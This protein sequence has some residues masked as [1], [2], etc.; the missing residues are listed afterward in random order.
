MGRATVMTPEVIGKLEEIF[1]LGG[2][3]KEACFFANISPDTLYEYCK[4]NE[5]YTERKEALKETPIL[6]AR[7]TVVNSLKEPENAKWYLERKK[8]AEF[9][10]RK[11]VTG[12]EGNAVQIQIVNYG[13][14]T[15]PVSTETVST[16]FPERMGLGSKEISESS[17]SSEWEGFGSDGEPTKEN[18]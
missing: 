6:Q 10:Q 14:P 16:Q 5:G 11:E 2:T 1:S 18:A 12:E 9:A 13:N 17:S 3:D 15:L 7:R 4:N 8:K